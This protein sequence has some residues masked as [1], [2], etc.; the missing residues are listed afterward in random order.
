M[1]NFDNSTYYHYKL[2]FNSKMSPAT[3]RLLF[4]LFLVCLATVFLF[5]IQLYTFYRIPPQKTEVILLQILIALLLTPI[6]HHLFHGIA[7]LTLGLSAKMQV[8][9]TLI[10]IPIPKWH[11]D[12][13]LTRRQHT[14]ILL[15]PFF[16]GTGILLLLMA[17][18]PSFWYVSAAILAIHLPSCVPD[19]Y[20]AWNLRKLHPTSVIRS[21]KHGFNVYKI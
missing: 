11:S 10:G 13:M 5:L 21:A 15:S 3:R 17:F 20:W 1:T 16:L 6:Y 14:Y 12:A 7:Y 4:A 19:L 2:I 18:F 9:D 8:S